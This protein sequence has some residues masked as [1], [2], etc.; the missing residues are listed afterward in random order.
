MATSR[1]RNS[2][3]PHGSGGFTVLEMLVSMALVGIVL[4]IASPAI[5]ELRNQYQLDGFSRQVAM[6]VS[7]ARMQAIAQN[8]TVRL[9]TATLESYVIEAS[10]DGL[11]FTPMSDPIFVPDGLLLFHGSTGA[12]AF[13]RQGMAPAV[14]KLYVYNGRD[15]KIIETTR[16]GRVSRS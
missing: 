9:R 3:G 8:R 1:I 6:Q 7:K 14:T 16:L 10:E 2:F 13:N 5:T 11:T 15:L 4:A 12:P